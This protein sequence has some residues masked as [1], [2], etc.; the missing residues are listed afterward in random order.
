[1]KLLIEHGADINASSYCKTS[2]HDIYGYHKSNEKPIL[3]LN[4]DD[5]NNLLKRID[6]YSTNAIIT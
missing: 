3:L 5:I 2:S 6:G 4:R 1:M